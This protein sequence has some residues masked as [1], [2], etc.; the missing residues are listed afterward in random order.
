MADQNGSISGLTD[1]EAREFHG[2]FM[3]GFIGFTI[4]AVV[5][6]IL[7]Y[8]WRPWLPPITGYKAALMD[9]ATTIATTLLS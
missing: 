1:A 2:L 3:Q 9:G 5:A 6:H 7:V 8:M 4:V